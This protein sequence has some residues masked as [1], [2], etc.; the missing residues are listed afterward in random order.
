[1][2][3]SIHVNPITLV[4]ALGTQSP[5]QDEETRRRLLQ[6]LEVRSEENA[7]LRVTIQRLRT[8]LL[9]VESQIKQRRSEAWVHALSG[10]V[11]G[12]IAMAAA[13]ISSAVSQ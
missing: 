1:M 11:L 10:F 4:K 8:Q 9:Y 2:S 12:A 3:S 5:T 7:A 6:T 13:W